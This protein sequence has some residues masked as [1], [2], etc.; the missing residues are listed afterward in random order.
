MKKLNNHDLAQA[1]Q[2]AI[3]GADKVFILE[4]LKFIKEVKNSNIQTKEEF[5][6][7]L[8][9]HEHTGEENGFLKYRNTEN[10]FSSYLITESTENNIKVNCI[11][12]NII[13]YLKKLNDIK[14]YNK[15]VT[16]DFNSCQAKN[17]IEYL[18]LQKSRNIENKL[19][20]LDY[21]TSNNHSYKLSKENII[22]YQEDFNKHMIDYYYDNL[23]IYSAKL[24]HF[25]RLNIVSDNL[26]SN[27]IF[28]SEYDVVNLDFFNKTLS[29]F[30]QKNDILNKYSEYLL[31]IELMVINQNVLYMFVDSSYLK[32]E[33]TD[34]ELIQKFIAQNWNTFSILSSLKYAIVSKEPESINY[35]TNLLYNL[36][37][38]D[39]LDFIH[40]N[41]SYLTLEDIYIQL[42][43]I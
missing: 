6:N 31:N 36:Y 7:L 5:R 12:N 21:M 22:M 42:K 10:I 11:E 13:S 19:K 29:T 40:Q 8:L 34:K 15:S 17:L 14:K 2:K 26:K 30:K 16:S 39:S 3:Y 4:K 18:T 35:I 27:L 1:R 37:E 24:K 38:Y 41:N 33:K 23:K 28:V 9:N 32:L 43:N 20:V 25:I